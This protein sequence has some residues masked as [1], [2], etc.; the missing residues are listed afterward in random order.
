MTNSPPPI[1]SPAWSDRTKRTIILIA[2]LGISLLL[3]RLNNVLPMFLVSVIIAYLLYPVALFFEMRLFARLLGGRRLP[4]LAI[5]LA[6][7]I[8]LSFIIIVIL[9]VF[10][11]VRSQFEEFAAAL[12]RLLANL[13][14][15]LETTLSQPL[16]F[17]GEPIL[18]DGQPFIPLERLGDL[19][20]TGDLSAAMRSFDFTGA[21][22]SLLSSLPNI[23]GQA[24]DVLGGALT[25][26]INLVFMITMIFYLMKDGKQ[27]VEKLVE[28]TPY[29]YRNDVRRMMYELG[30]VWNAYLR[31]QLLL[32]AVMGT[33]TFVAMTIIGLPNA[34]ILGLFVAL[35]EFLPGIGF[36]LGLIPAALLAL[37][38]SS[39]TLP[40]V[41]A[42]LPMLIVTAVTWS[43]LQQLE[44]I[45]LIPRIMGGSLNLHPFV[46]I[47]SVIVGANLLG[48]LGIVLATPVVASLRLVG[49]YV[50][51][52]LMD[53]NPFPTPK[54]KTI[55]DRSRF[56]R[57]GVWG[58]R[59]V[60]RRAR[61]GVR[62]VS[63]TVTRS[64]LPGRM[65]DSLPDEQQA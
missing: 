26:M 4:G 2:A 49:Q 34:I 63:R 58:G 13:A 23:T 33:V 40:F 6:F 42:G 39:A 9:V 57:W 48:V 37:F 1:T 36:S 38:N 46:V 3:L 44:G 28:I 55:E 52:K 29:T 19:F 61:S 56:V 31:G 59:W 21:I 8:V 35:L 65:D 53:Q 50:Y 51:G 17:N 24:F 30:R 32:C 12:P 47:A 43:L 16:T 18:I 27:F 62:G 20:G 64:P 45:I 41:D 22:Q 54:V 25:V 7:M 60:Y 14:I 11:L 10:P 15:Q 5:L